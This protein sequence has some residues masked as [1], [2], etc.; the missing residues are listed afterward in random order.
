MYENNI[1]SCFLISKVV[2][3]LKEQSLKKIPTK[4]N[5]VGR[6]KSK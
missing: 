4:D 6:C 1:C 2:G 5:R 3:N